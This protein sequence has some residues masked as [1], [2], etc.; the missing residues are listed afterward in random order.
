MKQDPKGLQTQ[1]EGEIEM[2]LHLKEKERKCVYINIDICNQKQ[3]FIQICIT[4]YPNCE[5]QNP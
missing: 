2:H 5:V 4:N 1:C 3:M